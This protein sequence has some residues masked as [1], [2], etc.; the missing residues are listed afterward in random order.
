MASPS[1]TCVHRSVTLPS[2]HKKRT[3]ARKYLQIVPHDDHHPDDEHTQHNGCR[4]VEGIPKRKHLID[5]RHKQVVPAHAHQVAQG[6][7]VKWDGM[8]RVHRRDGSPSS[9]WLGARAH[10]GGSC[11]QHACD[12]GRQLQAVS[13]RQE[14]WI[15]VVWEH[16]ARVGR[17]HEH[18]GSRIC[19]GAK[20]A[21][22]VVNELRLEVAQRVPARQQQSTPYTRACAWVQS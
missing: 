8:R 10:G 15:G 22:G 11:H 12:I 1:T 18:A 19:W 7:V 21:G 20:L 17:R 13:L 5:K 3:T 4:C 2:S 9:S 16:P 14:D 6:D